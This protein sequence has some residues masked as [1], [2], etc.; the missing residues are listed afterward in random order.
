[1]R[2]AKIEVET[3]TDDEFR[4][5]VID[6]QGRSH[7]RVT[8]AAADCQRLTGGR[9]GAEELIRLSFKFLLAREPKERSILAKFDLPLIGHYFPE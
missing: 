8:V 3:V 2:L 5:R 4:V 6:H 7:L 9:I 1:M